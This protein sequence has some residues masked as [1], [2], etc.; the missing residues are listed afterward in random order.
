M[1]ITV[2]EIMIAAA[3]DAR[4]YT[5]L[6]SNLAAVTNFFSVVWRELLLK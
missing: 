1:A 6:Y 5:I 2:M 3:S 4:M